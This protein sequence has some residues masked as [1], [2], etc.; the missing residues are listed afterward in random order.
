MHKEDEPQISGILCVVLSTPVIC[1]LNS[2]CL[3]VWTFC[4]VSTQTV[5][6]SPRPCTACWKLFQ[7]MRPRNHRLLL[8]VSHISGIT[9][10]GCLISSVLKTIVSFILSSFLGCFREESKSGPYSTL[11]RIN[12]LLLFI[13][14]IMNS[15][16]LYILFVL[17]HCN[18]FPF[19]CWKYPNLG[20]WELLHAFGFFWHVSISPFSGK[21]S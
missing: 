3:G 10:L 19:W 12:P 8:F 16:L 20:K 1:P 11:A 5:C 4:S 15:W 2:G 21:D 7:C 18:H 6:L 17:V 14:I 9:V 13:Y